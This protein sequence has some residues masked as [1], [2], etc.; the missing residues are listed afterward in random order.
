MTEKPKFIVGQEVYLQCGYKVTITKV[1]SK[2]IYSKKLRF[3]KNTLIIDSDRSSNRVFL[4]EESYRT[5]YLEPK[6]LDMAWDGFR[7]LVGGKFRCPESATVGSIN[8]AIE[9][10]GLNR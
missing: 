2:W 10:L 1:G 5:E 7:K 4:S 6:K 8:Q 9:M 3:D